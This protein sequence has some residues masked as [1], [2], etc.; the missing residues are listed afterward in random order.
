MSYFVLKFFFKWSLQSKQLLSMD[1][2]RWGDTP[3]S[4]SSQD[5][6]E[7]LADAVE[8]SRVDS[9]LREFPVSDSVDPSIPQDKLSSSLEGTGS[10]PNYQHASDRRYSPGFL[11]PVVLA[12]LE[13]ATAH[14]LSHGDCEGPHDSAKSFHVS[15][16]TVG[17]VQR[18]CDKGVIAIAMA[19]LCS[20]CADIRRVSVSILGIVTI[21]V[22]S[23]AAKAA[24]SWRD[25]PQLSMI[26]DSVQRALVCHLTDKSLDKFSVPRL[27]GVSAIFLAK[28][29][30]VLQRPGDRL[31]AT[32]NRVFL[33]IQKDCGAF[34][35]LWRVPA[36]IS[37]LC[38]SSDEP[39]QVASERAWALHL[40]RDGFVDDSCYKPVLSCHAPE[41]LV[42]TLDNLRLNPSSDRHGEYSLV[43]QTLETILRR[44]GGRCEIHFIQRLGLLSSLRS[45]VVAR[46]ILEALRSPNARVAFL[47]LAR[48]ILNKASALLS[49]AEF[50]AAT[51]CLGQHFIVFCLESVEDARDNDDVSSIVANTARAL[52][53]LANL[54]NRADN[55]IDFVK[56]VLPLRSVGISLQSAIDFVLV[57][58]DPDLPSFLIA[59][60][61]L[62]L[63]CPVTDTATLEAF[64]IKMLESLQKIEQQTS[65]LLAVVM[66]K[67]SK[68]LRGSKKSFED[69]NSTDIVLKLL[70]SMRKASAETEA[71]WSAWASCIFEL[72]TRDIKTSCRP[73]KALLSS[74]LKLTKAHGENI[75]KV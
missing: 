7:W 69:N 13:Y 25:R 74:A 38:S 21:T 59:V 19:A 18:L 60:C 37:L 49:R 53:A 6:W 11:L 3:K 34:Q 46:P 35:D 17:L 47:R 68:L 63:T 32:M 44:G 57:V 66:C 31:Y 62:P 28:A 48:V 51:S 70:L 65:S 5:H 45:F 64:C 4:L 50:S 40:L 23:E 67:I 2:L 39:E 75:K 55:D 16:H 9:T 42:T 20:Q 58:G 27:P 26:L 43:L 33:R 8:L 41:L 36:F 24:S 71:S 54:E 29:F 22:N 15:G 52:F 56:D 10:Q 30:R 72:T 1:R 61:C 73:E 12:Y 14:R